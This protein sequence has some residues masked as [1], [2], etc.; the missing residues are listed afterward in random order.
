MFALRIAVVFAL[1]FLLSI[2]SVLSVRQCFKCDSQDDF[3]CASNPKQD[4]F[5]DNC[6]NYRVQDS[7]G[8]SDII[9]SKGNRSIA[10]YV[11]KKLVWLTRNGPNKTSIRVMTRSCARRGSCHAPLK[12]ADVLESCDECGTH[13]CNS[14]IINTGFYGF[15]ISTA[16]LLYFGKK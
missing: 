13:L 11:C 3:E 1:C 2:E 15:I 12:M 9:D 5:V 16:M 10:E 4:K 14:S 8:D 6:S 7:P